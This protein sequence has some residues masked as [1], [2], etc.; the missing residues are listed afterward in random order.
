MQLVLLPALLLPGVVSVF[1]GAAGGAASERNTHFEVG[2]E[3]LFIFPSLFAF[4]VFV[5]MATNAFM[6]IYRWPGYPSRGLPYDIGIA[7]L[8]IYLLLGLWALQLWLE[9]HEQPAPLG[10]SG[11]VGPF[12]IVI[13]SILVLVLIRR[14]SAPR[15][16]RVHAQLTHTAKTFAVVFL[17]LAA[18]AV[19]VRF[20]VPFEATGENALNWALV[21]LGA[22]LSLPF[23]F[24]AWTA[25]H[26]LV[27]RESPGAS[28]ITIALVLAVPV[29][30]ILVAVILTL[31]RA[32]FRTRWA[33]AIARE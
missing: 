20:A 2:L 8:G 29:V 4:P 17:L 11:V 32:S 6:I 31:T 27:V 3:V 9:W 30:A 15:V 19:I 23:S 24:I 18:T 28:S 13:L 22:P 21:T 14:R 5:S 7:Q 26:V 10:W 16:D 25:V 12:A 1:A 33:P